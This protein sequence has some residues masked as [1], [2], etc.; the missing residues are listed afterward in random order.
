VDFF[1][2]LFSQ[3]KGFLAGVITATAYSVVRKPPNGVGIMLIAAAAGTLAD[4]SYGW[5]I[6]CRSE[7]LEWQK[8]SRR[9]TEIKSSSTDRDFMK[10][11]VNDT[12]SDF[13]MNND[14][15]FYNNNQESF[16]KEDNDRR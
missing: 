3:Y 14:S 8:Y 6:G 1:I 12:N 2:S 7:V 5:Q 10:Q 13:Q 11:N 15:G 16:T 9:L 4:W